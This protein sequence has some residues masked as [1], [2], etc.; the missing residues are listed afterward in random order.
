MSYAQGWWGH[1]CTYSQLLLFQG[2]GTEMSPLEGPTLPIQS[3]VPLLSWHPGS[4]LFSMP[5]AL[6]ILLISSI[7]HLNLLFTGS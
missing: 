6:Y 5:Y 2:L 1:R 7:G 4:F 3:A